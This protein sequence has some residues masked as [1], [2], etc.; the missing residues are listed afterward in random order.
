M[1]ERSSAD[2][3]RV[4]FLRTSVVLTAVLFVGLLATGSAAGQ[5]VSSCAD[6]INTAGQYEL[7][8]SI[9]DGTASTCIEINAD[10]VVLEGQ[11][12]SINGVDQDSGSFGIEVSGQT[13]VT[14]RNLTVTNWDDGILVL[15]SDDNTVTN[16][17]VT[18]NG[19]DGIEVRNSDN[20][21][22]ANNTVTASDDDGIQLGNSD[23][24]TVTDNTAN[25]N[26]GEG[27]YV[28]NS[29]DNNVT[30]NNANENTE[31]GIRLS[32]GS[33]NNVLTDN[34]A[35]DNGNDGILATVS[36]GNDLISNTLSS[37]DDD[38]INIVAAEGTNLTDNTAVSNSD[39]GIILA[40]SSANNLTDNEASLNS[41]EG[42]EL[43]AATSNDEGFG[44]TDPSR[45]NN[46]TD[47]RATSNG[48]N[49]IEL[50]N[51]A[52][53][54][55]VSDNIAFDNANGIELDQGANDNDIV[56]NNASQNNDNG[57]LLTSSEG[58]RSNN[59]NLTRNTANNNDD[60]G[61]W[62]QVSNGNTLTDN[63]ANDNGNSGIYL[64]GGIP[65]EADGNTL[66]DNT[67]NGNGAGMQP[68]GQL[69]TQ[70]LYGSGNS[71]IYLRNAD[72]NILEDNT[73]NDN[74]MNGI[75]IRNS[76][77]NEVSESL[78]EN[79][80]GGIVVDERQIFR[81]GEVGLES[82]ENTGNTF[83]DDTSRNNQ[84]DFIVSTDS[85]G[86][87]VFGN[88]VSGFPVT[89]LNIGSSTNPDTTLS[90]NAD[91]M[92]LRGID[93]PES[94]PDD[95]TN[96]GRY[97]EARSL[98][99]G[100]NIASNGELE[101][102]QNHNPFLDVSLSYENSDVSGVD[103]PT[104]E[105]LRFNETAS[106]WQDVPGSTVDTGNN[107]ASANITQFSDFG[108]F[109]E[110]GQRCINRRDL[111]RGQ[112]D[113][114]CPFDRDVQRGGTREGL[115]RDTGRGGTGEHRDSATSRRNR[116]RGE[117]RSR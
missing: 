108:V 53:N 90:F 116:G 59:N 86:N 17:T 66:V 92:E 32:Q 41:N 100:N 95:L 79:N 96:I 52:N 89:N 114:E 31:N 37:N 103:E 101:I 55:T 106:E 60:N 40:S 9:S 33:D 71:G 39:D 111:G 30:S 15:N 47:N 49:G 28:L 87:N 36:N 105:L 67:A 88:S 74:L 72:N 51:F 58:D 56:G 98:D 29:D 68:D 94:D 35:S 50:D 76:V 20:N 5:T 93:S 43:T 63:T 2:T 112:E 73:V 10:D 13:N 27:I 19:N 22:V 102:T 3:F 85:G 107:L 45:D 24:N 62:L 14:I 80:Y 99:G 21:T 1:G 6:D 8:Q 38:G 81:A 12:N 113:Q 18:G 75:W 64:G 91:N 104:L 46:I 48:D 97:F 69:G 42:I 54:N 115:D 82:V 25:D 7:N 110:P 26:G 109:G 78:A 57:I 44:L 34:T 16:N 117:G 23:D 84:W 65:D 11:G 83:T 4:K 77:D 61:I 70:Q